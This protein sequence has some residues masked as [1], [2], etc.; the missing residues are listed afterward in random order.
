MDIK[1]ILELLASYPLWAKGLLVVNVVS[2]IVILIFAPRTSPIPVIKTTDSPPSQEIE[3]TGR[4]T[5]AETHKSIHN[6]KVTIEHDQKVPQ[7]LYTDSDGIFHLK[8]PTSTKSVRIRVEATDYEVFDRNI[9]L[10]RTGIEDIRLTPIKPSQN[11]IP[12]LKESSHRPPKQS[13]DKA[14]LQEPHPPIKKLAFVSE[15]ISSP[16]EKQPYGLRVTI[17]T[18]T[19]INPVHLKVE[20]DG[21]IS[22]AHVSFAGP[23]SV[24]FNKMTTISNDIFEFSFAMPPFTPQTPLI[25][26]LFSRT[27]IQV[28][29]VS[30][31]F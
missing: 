24:M 31:V 3:Y 30:E 16:S 15:E 10:S 2:I 27:R 7:V 18:N 28:Q 29:K 20:C 6:V 23:T 25:V 12:A 9:S 22:E 26:T 17:Q 13:E 5:N 1:N 8:L 11:L 19:P 21:R 14:T 4:V